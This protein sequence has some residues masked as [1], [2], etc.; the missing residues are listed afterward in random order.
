MI[1]NVITPSCHNWRCKF[2]LYY[3]RFFLGG[4]L[5]VR[6]FKTYGIGPRRQSKP[7]SCFHTIVVFTGTC[8]SLWAVYLFSAIDDALGGDMFW[9]LGLHLYTPLP[10]RPGGLAERFRTHI[11]ATAGNL[12][13]FTEG[14]VRNILITFVSCFTQSCMFID[15]KIFAPTFHSAWYRHRRGVLYLGLFRVLLRGNSPQRCSKF[16]LASHWS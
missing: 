16:V 9:S 8:T 12:A 7:V 6:G 3:V 2:S 10:F 14:I 4:P 15:V 13:Q 1:I 5:S 11:F